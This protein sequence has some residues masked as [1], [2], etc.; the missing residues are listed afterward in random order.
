[1]LVSITILDTEMGAVEDLR[2]DGCGQLAGPGHLARRFARLELTTRYRP[3]HIHALLLGAVVPEACGSFLYAADEPFEGEAA[4]LLEALQISTE[5]KSRGVV[6]TEFQKR[7]LLLSHV[8]E[9]PV[10]ASGATVTELLEKQLPATIV[11]IRRSL[12]PKKIVVISK[13]LQGFV[14]QI[15]RDGGCPILGI[16]LSAASERDGSAAEDLRRAV[17]VSGAAAL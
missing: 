5:G 14:N 7:G 10:G 6:L 12:R 3:L 8:L 11:R 1:M 15:E 17:A 9:C 13:Q 16:E 4:M 2:C